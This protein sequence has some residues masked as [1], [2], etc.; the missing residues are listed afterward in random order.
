ME[1]EV[2]AASP[3]TFSHI[4]R[5]GRHILHLETVLIALYYPSALGSGNGRDPGGRRKWS[6]ELWLPHPRSEMSKGYGDFAQLPP[7]LVLIWFFLTTW[8]TKLPAFRNPKLA[9]HWPPEQNTRQGGWKVKN[10]NGEPPKGQPQE[11]IFPLIMFSHGLGGSRTAYSTVCGEFASYGCVL[12]A[13]EHRDG[14]GARTFVNHPAEGKGSRKECEASGGVDH[15]EKESIYSWDVIDFIFPKRNRYDTRPDNEQGIDKELRAAQIDMRLAEIQEAYD[16]VKAINAGD[17]S[18]ISQQNLRNADGMGGSSRGLLGV[19]WDCW[20]GRVRTNQVTMVGHSFGAAATVEVL[21][22]ADRFPWVGQGICYDVW[23]LA[24]KPPEL[25]PA[26]RISMPLLGINSEAFMYWEDNLQAAVAVCDEARMH[27]SLAWLLTV[28]GTVHIS[29][30]DFCILYPQVASLL[31]KQT[32][33]PRRAIDININASLEFLAQ[34]MPEPVAPFHRSCDNE[35]LL[36]LPCLKELPT[37]HKPSEKSTAIRLKVPH[38]AR[39]RIAPILKRNLKTGSDV[40]AEKEVWM[41]IAPSV[42]KLKREH[43]GSGYPNQ[44]G[45]G[46]SIDKPA[47][48]VEHS[49]TDRRTS[50]GFVAAS[51]PVWPVANNE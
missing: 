26:Y 44:Q 47:K 39:T 30:S 14:S 5:R 19:D 23:G 29:Q 38:E 22:H 31:L 46:K 4:T 24:V 41:H 32:I 40:D 6:R 9:S 16:I 17:G 37:V 42:D 33:S 12:C 49:D 3:R 34:V 25:D 21:R 10:E 7:W 28:R 43:L 20:T 27:G 51:A 50:K 1:I 35:K 13:V 45:E 11:P 8:F 2:P 36:E 48:V 15:L 18:A